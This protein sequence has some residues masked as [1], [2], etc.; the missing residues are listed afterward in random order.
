MEPATCPSEETSPLVEA[1]KKSKHG[2]ARPVTQPD[3]PAM[4]TGLCLINFSRLG[5]K[6]KQDYRF[7]HIVMNRLACCQILVYNILYTITCQYL[8]RARSVAVYLYAC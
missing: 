4:R 7:G 8:P 5:V 3:A 6:R 2:V 1:D